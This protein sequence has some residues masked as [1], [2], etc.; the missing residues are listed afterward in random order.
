MHR[1]LSPSY[2]AGAH[3]SPRSTLS[4][5]ILLPALLAC[6]LLAP[7]R[8]SAFAE[9]EVEV[10]R[11]DSWNPQR[12]AFFGDL[13]VHSSRSS[14][15]WMFGVRVTPDDAYR[16]A[17]GG[18]IELPGSE[19]I[20]GGG[21]P[22][23][24]D[25]PLDFAAVTDHAEFLGESVLCIDQEAEGW[26]SAFCQAFRAGEGR[27]P[28]L[29]LQ[30][31]SPWNWR[32]SEI[33]GE[34]GER[35]AAASA[36]AWRDTV[37]AAQ[38]W[39]DDTAACE[40]TTFP[41]YEY[42]SHRLGSNL[43]RN[44]IFRDA[45]VPP[46]VTSYLEAQREWDL[47][48]I[49]RRDCLDAGSGCDV[50][51]IPHNSNISNGRMFAVDYPGAWSEE[52]QRERA[53]LRARLEPLVEI[54][55]HKGDSECRPDMPGIGGAPDELCAFEKF[56]DTA[57]EAT[58]D[59]PPGLCYDG[60][61]ADWVPHLGPDCLSPRSYVRWAL[62]EGLREEERIGVNPFKLG[63]IASTDTH[64][65]MAGGVSEAN[66]EGHLGLGDATVAD[67]VSLSREIPGNTSNN[68]GG[69]VGVWAE[70][71]SR[72]AI[73]RALKRRE[74][75]GTS[76]PR[77]RLRFF[78]AA[79]FPS[80]LCGA[81]DMIE[82]A[83]RE[84]VAMGGD[85]PPAGDAGPSFLALALRDPGTS[86]APGA[87]LERI[88]IVKGWADR[89]GRIQQRIFD[90]AGSAP[91]RP[92]VDPE[93]CA[94]PTSG[95]DLLCAVWRDPEF[96][97]ETRAVYYLRVLE[98]PTCRYSRLQCLSLSP[99]ARPPDCSDQSVPALIQERAWSSPLWYAPAS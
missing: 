36:A 86:V 85:L 22:T 65:G 19:G 31:M 80:D 93:I 44:V 90:V 20:S 91:A 7:M 5:S 13:H 15:A 60:P 39:N 55:Q 3:R 42:S 71:N 46:Q 38:R 70:E 12:E 11:C 17:F 57:L 25:R 66:F 52:E 45:I 16:Y 14:D 50:L 51:A 81:P 75:F 24:I 72:D 88:Q 79:D 37:A 18:E 84:G 61:L 54:M 89:E 30:I 6:V 27:S 74:A 68:P 48:E 87:P 28:R 92:E 63:I 10:G 47:W 78:G 1:S 21:R 41:A 76:G 23:R 29:V 98:S 2:R 32:D 33:C 43:H 67:R 95:H 62:V 8:V 96:D 83:Y 97:P 69:L 40:R 99:D 59:D 56:E 4:R 34:E 64:N 77:I 49:L 73:F 94:P 35:C 58:E 9:P 26:D 82:R 53:R